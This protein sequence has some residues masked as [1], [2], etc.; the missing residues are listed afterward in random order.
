MF[1][2]EQPNPGDTAI[3][4]HEG[5]AETEQYPYW[6]YHVT[7]LDSWGAPEWQLNV[8][9]TLTTE[10]RNEWQNGLIEACPAELAS[11]A[12]HVGK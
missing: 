1:G 2:E 11:G 10:Y 6:G 3:I 8:R 7:Y 12:H 5:N 4:R 9:S